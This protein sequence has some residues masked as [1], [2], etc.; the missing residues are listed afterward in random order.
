[1][2]K[3]IIK[4]LSVNIIFIMLLSCNANNKGFHQPMTL[5]LKVPEGPI[6]YRAGWH[7]GCKSA[8][9]VSNQFLNSWV[10]KRKGGPDFGS[11]SFQ[12]LP[13]YQKGWSQGMFSCI[14]H[15]YT[16]VQYRSFKDSPLQSN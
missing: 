3:K 16:F 5:D 13:G 6:E 4:I 8:L 12:A 10:Y 1:M 7:D 14:L 11:G 2:Y 15:T 9:A